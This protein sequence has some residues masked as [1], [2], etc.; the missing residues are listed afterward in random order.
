[1]RAPVLLHTVSTFPKD[2]LT[3]TSLLV[4]QGLKV[5]IDQPG[6][7][8]SEIMTSPDF[9]V[10]LRL[11]SEYSNS[12][13]VVFEILEGGVSGTPSAII[14]DNYEA[15]IALL[16]GFASAAKDGVTAEHKADRRQKNARPQKKEAANDNAAVSRGVK[17]INLISSMTGRI[18]HLINQSHLESKEG[19]YPFSLFI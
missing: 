17:A 15:A 18:P 12:S 4:L 3:R 7:L 9:W 5:C 14:A 13:P 1:M 19:M 2:V 11:L 6:P 10:I 8:R 16:N